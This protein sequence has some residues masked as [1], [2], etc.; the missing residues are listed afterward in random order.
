MSGHLRTIRVR[1]RVVEGEEVPDAGDVLQTAKQGVR[2]LIHSARPTRGHP[3]G[4]G[5]LTLLVERLDVGEALP[6]GAIV[7]ELRWSR[8]ARR[9]PRA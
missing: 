4:S 8:Y 1:H 7:Y 5:R 6:A 9:G 2:Y 3:E